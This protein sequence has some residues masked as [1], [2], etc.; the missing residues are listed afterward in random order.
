LEEVLQRVVKR[1]EWFRNIYN[2]ELRGFD[3]VKQTMLT[4]SLVVV[5][6]GMIKK[7]NSF[8]YYRRQKTTLR[9]IF[10]IIITCLT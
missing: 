10:I 1:V 7:D 2:C 8:T 6:C 3:I 5:R 4:L 9:R